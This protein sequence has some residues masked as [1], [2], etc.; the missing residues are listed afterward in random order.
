MIIKL[1]M[2]KIQDP[3]LSPFTNLR[4]IKQ[5][6]SLSVIR[7]GQLKQL[8]AIVRLF[9]NMTVW[10]F[11]KRK[12]SI[13]LKLKRRLLAYCALLDYLLKLLKFIKDFIWLRKWKSALSKSLFK[14]GESRELIKYWSLPNFLKMS[15]PILLPKNTIRRLIAQLKQV[16][17]EKR[18]RKIYCNAEKG[19]V[20][21]ESTTLLLSSDILLIKAM[22]RTL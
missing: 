4:L 17:A 3:F 6:K 11:K 15:L 1:L 9:E 20:L 18:H 5:L 7:L 19:S 13:N 2:M 16:R 8:R 22:R 10:W 12:C 14:F 21:S